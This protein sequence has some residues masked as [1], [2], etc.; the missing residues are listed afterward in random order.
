MIS[1]RTR[2]LSSFISKAG[3]STMLNRRQRLLT[4]SK[5]EPRGVKLCAILSGRGV[6]QGAWRQNDVHKEDRP[7]QKQSLTL[8]Q[9]LIFPATHTRKRFS[10]HDA[11]SCRLLL[12]ERLRCQTL[13]THKVIISTTTAQQPHSKAGP[14]CGPPSPPPLELRAV[15]SRARWARSFGHAG[16]ARH[17]RRASASWT[18]FL[19][20]RRT[21]RARRRASTRHQPAAGVGRFDP[22][23]PQSLQRQAEP[24]QAPPLRARKRSSEW[25]PPPSSAL[26]L[27]PEQCSRATKSACLTKDGPRPN[28]SLRAPTHPARRA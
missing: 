14:L 22:V 5:K 24:A 26:L 9:H 16:A 8:G 18:A 25:F 4:A 15:R 23:F 13:I 1:P 19:C 3:L 21:S 10:E 12:R 17:R 2:P 6:W 11:V 7:I 20:P 27:L 28:P